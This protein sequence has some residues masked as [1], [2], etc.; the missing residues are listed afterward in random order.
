MIAPAAQ[1]SGVGR[2]V[3][4]HVATLVKEQGATELLTSI[5]QGDGT[6]YGFY[7]GLGFVPTGEYAAWGEEIMVLAL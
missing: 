1:G 5:A 2:E 4:R 6:P 7:L 3:V